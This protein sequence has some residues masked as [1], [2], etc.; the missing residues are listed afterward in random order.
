MQSTANY[1]LTRDTTAIQARFFKWT[2]RLFDERN[3]HRHL[4]A[5]ISD[6]GIRTELEKQIFSLIQLFMVVGRGTVPPLVLSRLDRN[7]FGRR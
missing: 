3:K 6:R 5:H 1:I 4:A 7:P 2:Y